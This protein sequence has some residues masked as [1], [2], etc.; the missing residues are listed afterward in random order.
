MIVCV[1]VCVGVCVCTLGD[2]YGLSEC[3]NGLTCCVGN[4][5]TCRGFDDRLD[6]PTIQPAQINLSEHGD[7]NT[8]YD[9]VCIVHSFFI[10]TSKFRSRLGLFLY[11]YCVLNNRPIVLDPKFQPRCSYKIVVIKK[12]VY[13]P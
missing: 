2:R 11:I 12:R 7:E 1:C 10:R 13:V 6:M 9:H 4:I 3:E 5:V 8:L